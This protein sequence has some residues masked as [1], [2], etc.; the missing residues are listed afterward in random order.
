MRALLVLVLA[1]STACALPYLARPQDNAGV[2]AV[3]G[4][5]VW[6]GILIGVDVALAEPPAPKPYCGGDVGGHQ[7]GE[8]CPSQEP[9]PR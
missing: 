9:A 7:P 1:A 3:D 2:V 4:N 5:A 6:Q 8:V